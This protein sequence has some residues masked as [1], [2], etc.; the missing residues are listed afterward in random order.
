LLWGFFPVDREAGALQLDVDADMAQDE[1]SA[2]PTPESKSLEKGSPERDGLT[3]ASF[4]EITAVIV[5]AIG[6]IV[7]ILAWWYPKTPS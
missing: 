2:A 4:W 5:T 7:A 1:K 6:V 3:V